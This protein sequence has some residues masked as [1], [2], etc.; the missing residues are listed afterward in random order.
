M[1]RKLV[2]GILAG[3]IVL[4]T[5]ASVAVGL[6]GASLWQRLSEEPEDVRAEV[7]APPSTV[8]GA[9]FTIE[10]SVE[11]LSAETVLL[12]SIDVAEGYLNGM[13]ISQS[14]PAFSEARELPFGGVQTYRFEQEIPPGETLVVRMIAIGKE[15]GDWSGAIDVCIDS[16]IRCLT[17]VAQT[18]V[19]E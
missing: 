12:D 8:K 18:V 15:A 5:V 6:G 3:F 10:I 11:N 16:G 4:C 9:P 13:D 14:E 2:L 7:K 17:S 1:N 19:E